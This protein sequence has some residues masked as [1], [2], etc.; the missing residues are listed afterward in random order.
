MASMNFELLCSFWT[1]IGF[2]FPVNEIYDRAR[3]WKKK[4]I[5]EG[6]YVK[7]KIMH[8]RRVNVSLCRPHYD[9]IF[10]ST[11][12]LTRALARTSRIYRHGEY[13]FLK[14]MVYLHIC[15]TF[16][17]KWSINFYNFTYFCFIKF[18]FETGSSSL[19]L[20]YIIISFTLS[21]TLP[22]VFLFDTCF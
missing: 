18:Q 2:Y 9:A 11:S 14:K 3:S 8:H 4:D 21:L 16:F 10:K 13:K 15:H 17:Q 12:L 22:F 5:W 20:S 7:I 6:V 19:Y 1:S